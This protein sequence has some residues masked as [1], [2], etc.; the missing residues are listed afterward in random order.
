VIRTVSLPLCGGDSLPLCGGDSLPLSLPA[1]NPR[2]QQKRV[3]RSDPVMQRVVELLSS[4]RGSA[5]RGLA[6]R[7]S[8]RQS[9]GGGGRPLDHQRLPPVAHASQQPPELRAAF[10][11]LCAELSGL[12]IGPTGI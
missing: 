1:G 9:A 2:V 5:G 3:D 10:G 11:P 4:R 7:S 8:V 6:P 12:V